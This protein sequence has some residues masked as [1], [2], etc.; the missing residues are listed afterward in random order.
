[1]AKAPFFRHIPSRTQQ[2][3]RF[4]AALLVL[5]TLLCALACLAGCADVQ[6]ALTS[7]PAESQESS[8]SA[9][10]LEASDKPIPEIAPDPTSLTLIAIG[11]IVAH[12]EMIK[13]ARTSEGT[14]DF[15]HVFAPMK[16]RLGQFDLASVTQETPLVTDEG[17]VGGY[18]IFGTPTAMGDAIV[19]TG[20]D[21]AVSAT[22]HSMDQGADGIL[23]T[24][25]FWR[26]SH[27]EIAVLGI[28]D[29]PSQANGVTFIERNGIRI[30]L[31]DCT[32]G[33]N[34]FEL[35]EGREYEVDLLDDLDTILANVRTAESEADI[36]ICYVH[37]G[38]E[39]AT[40][41]SDWQR[42]VAEALI[43]AG[44]EVVIGSH[45]H[46]VQP[47]EDMTTAAGNK[48][49]VYFS[50]GNSASNQANVENMLGGAAVLTIE[51]TPTGIGSETKTSV[52]AHEFV[53]T[54]CH[55]DYNTTQMFFLSDY[56]E[57]QAAN[58]F[59]TLYGHPFT[60]EQ[61]RN[62]WTDI[63]GLSL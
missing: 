63:T 11:D 47:M 26:Q 3:P 17:K 45:V 5:A 57:E 60:V 55:Y 44:A 62:L 61:V 58:H 20:F 15:N 39:Y 38:E 28:H 10:I 6:S 27:P 25:A 22:N 52:T 46:V 35:P 21:I 49:I 53:P 7:Q 50:L 16:D 24:I 4:F 9:E 48:G 13:Q 14:Y 1:M 32:Y 51:K 31:T 43:D 59:I 2:E 41:P 37:M 56:T 42:A 33:L 34:G 40:V 29:D 19:N 30:A 36:T 12:D 8:P 23:D 54:F 18:P